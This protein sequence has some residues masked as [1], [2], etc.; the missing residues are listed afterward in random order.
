MEDDEA[1]R[2][3]TAWDLTPHSRLGC[4]AV[5]KGD[6]VC[7]LPMY[8]RNYVQEGGGIQLGKSDREAEGRGGRAVKW[9]DA[10]DIGIALVEKFPGVDPLT[11]R[12]PTC[13]SGCWRSTAST[14]TQRRRTSPSSRPSR[15][16]GTR[17]SRTR[18]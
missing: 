16:P 12:S 10:E 5:I 6:V 9:T 15:W 17:S 4:Q 7:E 14:T 13:A 8:T 1:D 3:D 2:L 18:S 11:V